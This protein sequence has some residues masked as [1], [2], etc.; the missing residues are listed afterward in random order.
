MEVLIR[1][2]DGL[3][4]R[5]IF[6]NRDRPLR[7]SCTM[8]AMA[9]R[10]TSFD[11]VVN[12]A[13]QGKALFQ[14]LY[15]EVRSAILDGRL[16]RGMRLPSTRELALRY[17]VSR[18][19]VVAAFEQLQS[20]GY[21]EG[22]VGAGTHVTT[23]LPED[24]LHAKGSINVAD[25]Q[26]TYVPCLSHYARRVP[27]AP[28]MASQPV[29]AFRVATPALDAFPLTLWAQISA[30]R[31][32]KATRSLLTD[33]DP[34]GYRPLREAISNYLGIARG[35]RCTPD[36]VII[37][38]GIQQGLDLTA[39]LVLNPGD[40]V[41]VEDPCFFG[42]PAM[43]RA[44]GAKV[45]PVP[46]DQYGLKVAEGRRRSRRA[47]LACVTPAHQFPLGAIMPL[48]RR[49]SLLSW[50]QRCGS[51]IFEDDYDSEYRYCG[52]PIPTLQGLD[53]AG[54]VVLAGSF[55]KLLFPSLRLGYVVVP[56]ALVDKFAS[57]KYIMD[58]YSVVLDQAVLC[59]FITEGHFGRHIRRMR[60]VYAERFA[61]LRKEVQSRLGGRLRIPD[62][63]AG[64]QV[65]G[66]LGN[67][68]DAEAVAKTAI[69]FKVELVPIGR[70]AIKN[71]LPQGLLLGFGAV[72]THELLRGVD[73]LARAIEKCA[74][75]AGCKRE[76]RVSP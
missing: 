62:I 33:A 24:F 10:T 5:T 71:P 1:A 35:A 69:D 7:N 2:V 51:L 19:T 45:V 36:Q 23:L 22:K 9:K 68:L 12:S 11:F 3:L 47:K 60:E 52:H 53:Q 65:V 58:R 15:D 74:H 37:V 76:L 50:A 48:E 61:V 29:R 49:L 4:T 70:F 8:R 39:R 75:A 16:K 66:W 13:P 56:P 25:A 38:A 18:G 31:L 21:L 14:W 63:E 43:F 30:R 57:V 20:E 46:V 6:E 17:G 67:G 44:L 28:R 72:G 54:M 41:W 27:S 34:G 40:P 59:D 64:V 42:V 26:K 32:R 55:S 73:G